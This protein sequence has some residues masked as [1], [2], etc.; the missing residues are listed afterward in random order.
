MKYIILFTI[1]DTKQ[2]L[3]LSSVDGKFAMNPKE[4]GKFKDAV[5]WNTLEKAKS[6]FEGWLAGLKPDQRKTIIQMRPQIVHV[7]ADNPSLN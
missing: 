3:V 7:K 2:Q 5:S 1:P 6:D 4:Q